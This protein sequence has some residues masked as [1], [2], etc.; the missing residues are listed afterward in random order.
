MQA[1][2][3]RRYNRGDIQVISNDDEDTAQV[4]AILSD[5]ATSNLL[6][7]ASRRAKNVADFDKNAK[8]RLAE[9]LACVAAV[10][11]RRDSRITQM[12]AMASRLEEKW[13]RLYLQ[14]ERNAEQHRRDVVRNKLAA[15][16]CL[17]PW[18]FSLR[19]PF[20]IDCSF[21]LLFIISSAHTSAVQMSD[22]VIL[23]PT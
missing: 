2:A 7:V 13:R 9:K 17:C 3:K 19:C 1:G 11:Q 5:E 14:R 4:H 18:S 20:A 8:R 21:M 16:R 23:P 15:R 10:Q 22:A 6:A 12:T